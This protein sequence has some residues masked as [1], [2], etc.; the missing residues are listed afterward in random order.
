MFLLLFQCRIADHDSDYMANDDY[1]KY[2]SDIE[3]IE[4]AKI[5]Q[6][7]RKMHDDFLNELEPLG[8]ENINFSGSHNEVDFM[9]ELEAYNQEF[10]NAN[11][12]LSSK[13][14]GDVGK[15]GGGKAK[16]ERTIIYPRFNKSISRVGF[17]LAVGMLFR[18]K[19]QLINT[20]KNYRIYNGYALRIIT[21]DR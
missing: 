11:N 12:P 19:K 16:K 14:N 17:D 5:R 1:K 6:K 9:D 3:D 8:D 7:M 18:D 21:S 15:Q 10:Y 2:G 4:F 13:E 20:V